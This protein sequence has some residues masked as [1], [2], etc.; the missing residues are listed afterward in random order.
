M[1]RITPIHRSVNLPKRRPQ[2]DSL[3]RKNE[4]K[5]HSEKTNKNKDLK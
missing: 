1:L 3:I 5:Q 4:E 2:S